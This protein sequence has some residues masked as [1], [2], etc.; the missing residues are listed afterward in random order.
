MT[1]SS[2]KAISRGSAEWFS[3]LM[4]SSSADVLV[5]LKKSSSVMEDM[6]CFGREWAQ[7]WLRA[8][9]SSTAVGEHT[10]FTCRPWA[11]SIS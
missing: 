6:A 2:G 8:T 10:A 7:K 5:C 4:S 9:H 1:K 3:S 11:Q